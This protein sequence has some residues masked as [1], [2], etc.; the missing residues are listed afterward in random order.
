MRRFYSEESQ[1]NPSVS[2]DVPLRE[3]TKNSS[4]PSDADAG[5]ELD[6]A[7]PDAAASDAR[8]LASYDIYS[9]GD[10]FQDLTRYRVRFPRFQLGDHNGTLFTANGASE[11]PYRAVRR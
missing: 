9:I 5:A 8:A 6:A 11:I 7:T 1:E 10:P 2:Y 4:D 3:I